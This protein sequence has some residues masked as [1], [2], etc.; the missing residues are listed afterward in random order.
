M[1]DYKAKIEPLE[2][3]ISDLKKAEKQEI[4]KVLTKEQWARYLTGLSGEDKGKTEKEKVE[5]K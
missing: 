2:K 1:A 5:K 4:M 3:Q